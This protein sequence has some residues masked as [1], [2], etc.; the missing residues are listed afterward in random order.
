M[1]SVQ[2]THGVQMAGQLLYNISCSFKHDRDFIYLLFSSKIYLLVHI[3]IIL[4]IVYFAYSHQGWVVFS[5]LRVLTIID[6]EFQIFYQIV[7]SNGST[8]LF[9]N[10]P[11]AVYVLTLHLIIYNVTS[12]KNGG[13]LLSEKSREQESQKLGVSKFL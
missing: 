2:V 5:S 13:M 4:V 9:F 1:T 7:N 3:D 10:Q 12:V 6:W 8:P 11:F